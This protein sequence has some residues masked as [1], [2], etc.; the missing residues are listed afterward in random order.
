MLAIEWVQRIPNR[1]FALVTGITTG[2]LTPPY[3]F[4]IGS[5][6]S[7]PIPC[8][9]CNRSQCTTGCQ[10]TGALVPCPETSRKKARNL[11][12]TPGSRGQ[13]SDIRGQ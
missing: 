11:M 5:F 7:G 2:R 13:M 1:N 8:L 10:M 4:I 9:T 6:L 3:N 12:A